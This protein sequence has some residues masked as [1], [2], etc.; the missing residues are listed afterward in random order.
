MRR[1]SAARVPILVTTI[2][3]PPRLP[4]PAYTTVAAGAHLRRELYFFNL[5]RLLAAAMLGL[6]L[7]GPIG[8]MV[9]EPT[10]PRLAAALASAYLLFA[11]A[12]LLRPPPPQRLQAQVL[13]G[14]GIDIAVAMLA[15]WLLPYSASTIAVLLL[16]GVAA[17]AVLLPLRPALSMAS[18]AALALILQTAWAVVDVDLDAGSVV[19]RL[20]FA[21]GYIAAALLAW[22][23]AQSNRES[24]D[25]AR[26]QGRQ[27]E[28][29]SHLNELVIRRMRTGVLLVDGD[30]RIR[31][32]NEAA[33]ALL[34]ADIDPQ[35]VRLADISPE[36]AQQLLAWRQSRNH[37]DQPLSL[38]Q[39]RME[40]LPRI[41]PLQPGD[42]AALIFLD[43]AEQVARRAETISLAAMGR[44]SA[45]L[46]HEIRNPLAAIQYATQL[47]EESPDIGIADRR[48]LDIV[49]QQ[50]L[51]TN[52]IIDSVLGMARRER[53]SPQRLD[54][55][56]QAQ[57]FLQEYTA[58]QPDLAPHLGLADPP[59][60][61]AMAMVD[62]QQLQQVLAILVNNAM[63]HGRQPDQPPRVH[64]NM[65]SERGEA[66]LDV[67]DRGPGIPPARVA[68]LFQPFN[69][70]SEH[71]TGLGL[72]IARELCR[73]NQG[74][75]EYRPLPGGG[76]CFRIRLPSGETFKML[77]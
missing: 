10:H 32:A 27:L 55:W 28:T 46:A 33:L 71:G 30:G 36:L 35:G 60:G 26:Q 25:L 70:T 31:L 14:V 18:L 68:R 76:S 11:L 74:Q 61:G 37:Q 39:D 15:I 34:D 72:Y 23:L 62:P 56:Q 51:R 73:A 67:L 21:A 52:A 47:L 59:P 20:L 29:L 19:Q 38:G 22:T 65:G 45:S 48:L 3:E 41:L 44:F 54:L 1:A 12:M 49:R 16:F 2:P 57:R 17:A 63:V 50:C 53:A 42:E 43:D 9:G 40:V 7:M 13:A 8:A 5:Y 58:I 75:L 4:L 64:I 6:L 24:H 77:G 66:W 69:T